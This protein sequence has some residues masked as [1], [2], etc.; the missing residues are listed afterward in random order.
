[1]E[2]KPT[3][4]NVTQ[5]KDFVRQ[6]LLERDFK[7][8]NQWANDDR[9]PLRTMISLL[10]EQ[11]PLTIWRSI[12]GIGKVARIVADRDIEKV[13]KLIRRLFWLMNDESG[14]LCRRGPEAIA[15]ILVNVPEIID[16]YL[17]LLPS[18]LWEEPFER[19]TRFAIY[20]LITQKR[21][22]SE[23]FKNCAGDLLKSLEHDDELIRG[24]SYLILKEINNSG[25]LKI[26]IPKIQKTTIRIYDFQSGELSAVTL[27]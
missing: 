17:P 9:N 8:L 23:S 22:A 24:Y 25:S 14:G 5:R 16:E 26:E 4:T 12:E 1:M 3:T 15:E 20:R 19:G 13:R 11:D 10:F 7:K 6:I 2:N 21:S 27:P 18:F